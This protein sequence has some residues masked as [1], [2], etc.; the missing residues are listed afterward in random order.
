MERE[1]PLDLTQS[2]VERCERSAPVAELTAAFQSAI[3]HLGF[4]HFAC[5]SHVNPGRP[6]ANAVVIH[7]YPTDWVRSYA[8][9]NLHQRDPVFHYAERELLPFRWETPAF[10]AGLTSLQ[11]RLLQEAAEV[12]IARGYTVPI[13]LPWTAGALRASCSV[14]PDARSIDERAYRAVQVMAV[15]LYASA[16]P[17]RVS[18]PRERERRN[19]PMLSARE[20][21]CLELAAEG[22]SD[23]DISQLLKISEHTVHKHV[24][25]AKH[26]LGVST[27]IQAIVWAVQHR[28]ICFGGVV[29]AGET[30]AHLAS[31]KEPMRRAMLARQS[32]TQ[33][34]GGCADANCDGENSS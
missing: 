8:E 1:D 4:R 34:G 32:R 22:K 13:H 24:E 3:Q 30:G 2:F 10:R 9:R 26:R 16:E 17:R 11:A 28:E 5:C 12:G 15:Y 33:R 21:Q 29:S 19:G 27:R 18:S 23:W 25:A 6:P 20:S 14:I 31:M 7:N